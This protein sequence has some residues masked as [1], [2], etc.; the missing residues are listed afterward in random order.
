MTVFTRKL[1]KNI[2]IYH[3]TWLFTIGL[4]FYC[5]MVMAISSNFRETQ[6]I[7]HISKQ[8]EELYILPGR[9]NLETSCIRVLS[10]A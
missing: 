1:F 4:L 3:T 2:R 8:E 9:F 7:I 6:L 10:V 5:M